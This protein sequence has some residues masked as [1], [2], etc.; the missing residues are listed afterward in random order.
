MCSRPEYKSYQYDK[1]IKGV[2]FNEGIVIGYNPAGLEIK[3]DTKGLAAQEL[4][5]QLQN[6]QIV[7]SEIDNEGISE[8]ER[9]A[10][11]RGITGVERYFILSE[12]GSGASKN[13]HIFAAYLCFAM[14]TRDT[15]VLKKKKKLGKAKA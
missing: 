15:S 5:L 4:V 9:I 13:D 1:I 3:Q 7:L 6:K 2:T 12:K 10:K 14:L 8:L 11:Q